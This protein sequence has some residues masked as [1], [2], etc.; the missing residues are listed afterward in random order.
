LNP[1]V[2]NILGVPT[3]YT[4]T[5]FTVTGNQVI[6]SF[7]FSDI[8]Q[9]GISLPIEAILFLQ[10]NDAGEITEVSHHLFMLTS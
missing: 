5:G 10:F 2:F 8:H 3:N 7:I 1:A 4:I 6:G 9:G